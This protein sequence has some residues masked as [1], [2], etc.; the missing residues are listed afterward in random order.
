[1]INANYNININNSKNTVNYVSEN[2]TRIFYYS[3]LC[4]IFEICEED[5]TEFYISKLYEVLLTNNNLKII[6]PYGT[7]GKVFNNIGDKG[8]PNIETSP[9]NIPS[10]SKNY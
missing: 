3:I 9:F 7:K 4:Y 6:F 10:N 2:Q 5:Q 1:M 8:T